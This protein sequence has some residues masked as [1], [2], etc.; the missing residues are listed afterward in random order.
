MFHNCTNNN[1]RVIECLYMQKKWLFNMKVNEQT[2][3]Q[4]EKKFEQDLDYEEWLMDNNPPP[5]NN[6]LNQMEKSLKK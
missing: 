5:T 1:Y 3:K 4:Q 2:I 6:E